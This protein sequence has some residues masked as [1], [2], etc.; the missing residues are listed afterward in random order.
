MSGET[1]VFST[2]L[3]IEAETIRRGTPLSLALSLTPAD[4]ASLAERFDFLSVSE[5][6]GS[7]TV[8]LCATLC[9]ELTAKVKARI[10]QACV[11]SGEPVVT[12]LSFDVLERFVSE[13]EEIEEIDSTGVDVER[14]QD[15]HIPIGDAISQAIAICAP[16]YPRSKTAPIL[17]EPE[18]SRENN[19]F[20][21][22]S[23]LKK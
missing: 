9:W 20:A 4:E 10:E 6:S 8:K 19:P 13:S 15:G 21:K 3:S 5:V 12:C 22:L 7:V 18:V 14:L 17:E 23:E 2:G 1:P 11:V 16:A